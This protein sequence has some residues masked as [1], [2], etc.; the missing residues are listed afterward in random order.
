MD[1]PAYSFQL[2]DIQ[3]SNAPYLKQDPQIEIEI[4]FRGKLG[5]DA[6][7]SL[8][9][10]FLPG[11]CGRPGAFLLLPFVLFVLLVSFSIFVYLA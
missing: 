4:D 11:L 6:F 2:A 5:R 7:D 8:W 10:H 3:V 9:Q 1:L